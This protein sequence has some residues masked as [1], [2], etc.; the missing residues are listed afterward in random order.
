MNKSFTNIIE[1]VKSPLKYKTVYYVNNL[2]K[3]K[4][5][6]LEKILAV[7]M[8]TFTYKIGER[9]EELVLISTA[10][11]KM[12]LLFVPLTKSKLTFST[13]R[14]YI[15]VI[16]LSVILYQIQIDFFNNQ[17]LYKRQLL[18]APLR[19]TIFLQNIKYWIWH[20]QH[21]F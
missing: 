7:S 3:W 2:F 21:S 5:V 10:S 14:V 4:E 13:P 16:F 6:I 20:P 19:F 15:N 11:T 17:S 9:T 12:S 1:F 8:S 18:T